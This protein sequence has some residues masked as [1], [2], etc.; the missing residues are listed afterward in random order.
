MKRELIEALKKNTSVFGLMS[1]EMQEAAKTIG[2]DN[3]DVY[4]KGTGGEYSFKG[5][6]KEKYKGFSEYSALAYRLRADYRSKIE[7]ERAE[8]FVGRTDGE[9]YVNG[10]CGLN[11]NMAITALPRRRDFSHFEKE[12]GGRI[13]L[14]DIAT[15]MRPVELGGGGGKVYACVIK[16]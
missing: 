13:R 8:I 3:F 9:L 12:S 4:C 5:A 11:S 14:E 1:P 16:D 15:E 10:I 2:V 6:S 7:I